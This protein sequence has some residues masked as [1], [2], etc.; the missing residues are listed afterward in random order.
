MNFANG[1]KVLLID[2]FMNYL[3]VPS[4]DSLYDGS[5]RERRAGAGLDRRRMMMRSR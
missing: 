2:T 3:C 1:T 5:L 4:R